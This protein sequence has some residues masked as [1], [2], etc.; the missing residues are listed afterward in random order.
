MFFGVDGEGIDVNTGRGNTGEVLVWLD[1]VEVTTLTF[2][3]TVITVELKFSGRKRIGTGVTSGRGIVVPFIDVGSN[4]GGRLTDPSEVF[5]G[6]IEGE[7]EGVGSVGSVLFTFV[8]NLFNEILVDGRGEAV[9]FLIFEVDVVNVERGS[10][11]SGDGVDSTTVVG[12]YEVGETT[13]LEDEFNFVTRKSNKGKSER[14]VT[15]EPE[16]KGDVETSRGLRSCAG[17]E[18]SSITDHIVITIGT[19][20]G[21][22]EFIEDVHPVTVLTVNHLTTDLEF[23][24]VNE[25]VTKV[26]NPSDGATCFGEG[27]SINLK[28]DFPH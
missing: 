14:G 23:N 5:D 9:T 2:A 21:L 3:E 7:T 25:G 13:E 20:S 12:D 11:V 8:L 24:V 18:G 1:E 26:T 17:S 16:A 28:I 6:V 22:G 27:G 4:V 15:V 19:F 10:E